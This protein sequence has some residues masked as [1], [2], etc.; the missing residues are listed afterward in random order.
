MNNANWNELWKIK[1]L[2]L[3]PKHKQALKLLNK[4]LDKDNI[5]SLCD[6]GCGQ[7]LLLKEITDIYPNIEIFGADNN[8]YSKNE[9][10]KLNINYINFDLLNDKNHTELDVGILTD[11]LEHFYNPLDVINNLSN[12]KYLIIIVPNFN[13]ITERISV[14][15]GNVPFQMKPN[16]GGHFFWFNKSTLDE[17]ISSSNYEII[18]KLNIYP[19]K[20]DI[21]PLL[22]RYNNLFSTSFGLLLRKKV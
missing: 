16:R 13:F 12:I 6:F 7:G 11:V 2:S 4:L 9:I 18:E 5:S 17:L 8:E 22:K 10:K 3:Q 20:L 21:F 15:K 1:S 19:K 14:L